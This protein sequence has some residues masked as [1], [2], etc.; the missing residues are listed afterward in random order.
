MRVKELPYELRPREKLKRFGVKT[1]SSSELLAL[2][3]ETGR[4]G[5]NVLRIAQ[6]MLERFGGLKGVAEASLEDLSRVS[7]VKLAKAARLLAAFE[8]G[9]R[10][11]STAFQEK[12]V[13]SSPQDVV[14]LL[15]PEM[16]H[17][18]REHFK[19]IILSVKNE[20][21]RVINV[22][23]GNLSSAL[24]HPR[25]LF[26]EAIRSSGAGVIVVHNHPS[27]QP[28]PSQEDIRI[29]QRLAQCGEILGIELVDHVIL[30]KGCFVSMREEKLLSAEA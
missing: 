15:S 12:L 6:L 4:K 24:V 13:I 10:S 28:A 20:V 21:I 30:G 11:F 7:G 23:V 26:K 2:L 1:L 29:T 14:D 27:G 25:E 18:D 17:L 5:E 8:L 3:L 22:A 16:S 19:A 9:R